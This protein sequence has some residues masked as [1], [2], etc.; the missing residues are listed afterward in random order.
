MQQQSTILI[1]LTLA[2]CGLAHA[3][4][5]E[6]QISIGGVIAVA[7]EVANDGDISR[8]R[9]VDNGTKLH[10]KG[11][12]EIGRNLHFN[13]YVDS[14]IQLDEGGHGFASD[15]SWVEIASEW[16]SLRLGREDTPY[17]TSVDDFDPFVDTTAE[18]K[19]LLGSYHSA[20]AEFSG[21]LNN[22]VAI[23][24][25]NINGFEFALA[26][27][28]TEN[29][30]NNDK[31]RLISTSLAYKANDIVAVTAY[32]QHRDSAGPEDNNPAPGDKNWAA[33]VGLGYNFGPLFVGAVA[34]RTSFHSSGSDAQRRDAWYLSATY[35]IGSFKLLATGGKANDRSN[36]GV[37]SDGARQYSLGLDYALSKRTDAMAYYSKI[38]NAENGQYDFNSNP[39]D[40]ALGKD[41]SAFGLM[42]RH[43]F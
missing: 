21:L 19:A 34:E 16:A 9:L 37:D 6:P 28:T 35:E 41:P 12:H 5:N 40:V 33:R 30:T 20:S 38:D 31:P 43:R 7:P 29:R 17:K 11:E 3:E 15:N 24:S 13:W 10:I 32:E 26:S 8:S 18:F 22:S 14:R 42:L 4:G 2:A 25:A 39:L 27:G 36:N 23:H 1:G